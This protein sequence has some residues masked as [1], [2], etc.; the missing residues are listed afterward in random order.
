MGCA[1]PNPGS[2]YFFATFN[3]KPMFFTWFWTC[4]TRSPQWNSYVCFNITETLVL[5][6]FCIY[7]ELTAICAHTYIQACSW[8]DMALALGSVLVLN[9]FET[10]RNARIQA[11]S[12]VSLAPAL[13]SLCLLLLNLYGFFMLLKLQEAH[14][15]NACS[16]VSMAPALGSLWL[17]LLGLYGFW[18]LLSL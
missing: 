6:C 4:L 16:W 15:F 11:C 5:Y 8:V 10:A 12:W 13:G 2:A 9:A 1:E 7:N 18:M 3:I 17:L 14:A